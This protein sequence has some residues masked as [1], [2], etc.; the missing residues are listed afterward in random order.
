MENKHLIEILNALVE[1][2]RDGDKGF[3]TCAAESENPTLKAYFTLCATRCRASIATLD[4]AVK[5]LGGTTETS[6]TVAEGAHRAWLNLRTALTSHNDLPVLEECERAEDHA[7]KAY[8]SALDKDLPADVRTLVL[9]Q[10]EGVK[11]HH[12]RVRKMRDDERLVA[13]A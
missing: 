3:T 6:G 2:S 4:A 9:A 5:N 8:A 12:D 7:L 10:F 11:E 13:A 1:T